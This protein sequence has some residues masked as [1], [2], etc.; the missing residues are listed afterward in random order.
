M[1]KMIS[2]L[3][4]SLLAYLII[5][6]IAYFHSR[7]SEHRKKE[8]KNMLKI[9]TVTWLLSTVIITMIFSAT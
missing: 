1:E 8:T 9:M 5:V 2:G 6:I 3:L 7:K 4:W